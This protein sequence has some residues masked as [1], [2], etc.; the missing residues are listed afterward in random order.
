MPQINQNR[1]FQQRLSDFGPELGRFLGQVWNQRNSI[2]LRDFDA[3]TYKIYDIYSGSSDELAYSRQK[4]WSFVTALNTHASAYT[5]HAQALGT[6]LKNPSEAFVRIHGPTLWSDFYHVLSSPQPLKSIRSRVY[7]HAA[8]ADA[9]LKIMKII[10]GQFAK[11]KGL[12]EAKTAGP[13]CKRLDTIVCYL[14]DGD[15]A[16]ALVETLKAEVSGLVIDPLPPLVKNLSKGIGVAD[17]PPAVEIFKGEGTRHSFGSFFSTL[18]WIALKTTP[19][20]TTPKAD[21]RHMLDNMLFSLRALQVD[22]KYPQRFPN[23]ATLENWFR[24]AVV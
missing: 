13:G 3:G 11:N 16:D 17:E 1:P 12:W 5:I 21:G 15:S 6:V 22:P 9:S 20:V 7:V 23:A 19:N 24:K 14:Y 4:L 8:N 2:N 10:I 18:C